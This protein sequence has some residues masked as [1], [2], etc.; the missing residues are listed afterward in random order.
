MPRVVNSFFIGLGVAVTLTHTVSSSG[1]P[2]WR[3]ISLYPS[4]RD[5]LYMK[6]GATVICFASTPPP[7]RNL[8]SCR[9]SGTLAFNLGSMRFSLAAAHNFTEHSTA[10]SSKFPSI[11]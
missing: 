6:D 1:S 5:W 7:R 10:F 4:N 9:R 3:R 2:T 8:W 11:C